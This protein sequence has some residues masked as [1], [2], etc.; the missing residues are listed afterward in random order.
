MTLFTRGLA[1]CAAVAAIAAADVAGSQ[2]QSGAKRVDYLIA[3]GQVYS[4]ALEPARVADVGIRGDRIVFIG[5]AARAGVTAARRIVA[6][7]QMVVPGFIDAHVHATEEI[8]STNPDERALLRQLTQGVTTNVIGV[9]GAGTPDLTAFAR[10]AEKAGVGGNFAAYVGFGAIRQRVLGESARA[11]TAGELARMKGMAEAAMCQGAIGISSGL[12]YAPQSFSKTEEVI[13]VARAAAG[14]IYDTH[15]RDEGTTS[16]G[17]TASVEEAMRIARESGTKLHIGHF[18]V[19]S[20]AHPDGRAMAALIKLIEAARARG[21]TIT[22]DQ[23][24]W[25]ASN[26]GLVAMAIPRWAQDGGREAMLKRFADPVQRARILTESRTFFAER[27]GAQNILINGAQGQPQLVGRRVSEIAAD[28]NVEPAEAAMRILTRGSAGVAIFAIMEADIRA[29]MKRPWTM[30]SSDG[31]PHGHPRGHAS[32]P[33]LY[34]NY[35][36]KGVITPVEFVHKSS[37]LV[38]DTLGLTG[39]GYLR[40]GAFADVAVIDPKAFRQ[41]ATFVQPTLLSTGVRYVF[42][43]GQLALEGGRATGM[44][45]GRAL[46]RTPQAGACV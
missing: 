2:D 37:G 29:L 21:E 23:Y 25:T 24:P 38:A 8:E 32:Y 31:G 27:G 45:P 18:K 7:G 34:E 26:T 17:V 5:N 3:G 1:A 36:L 16:I 10:A 22:A 14:G 19:S 42:V 39:R 15:Q 4:G 6:T 11:P 28:W 40:R 43:N 41:R 12:F 44:K 35:V 9:D 13:E 46:L 20:G 33:R 30:F